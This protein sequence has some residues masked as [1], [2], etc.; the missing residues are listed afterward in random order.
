MME[1]HREGLWVLKDLRELPINQTHS[2]LDFEVVFQMIIAAK[3]SKL[4]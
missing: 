2:S 4:K 1:P 3:L